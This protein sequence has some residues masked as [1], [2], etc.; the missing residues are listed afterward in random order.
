M[1]IRDRIIEFR[2]VS[3]DELVPNPKNW[4][5]HSDLQRKALKDLVAQIGFVGAELARLLPDGRLMLIDGHLR[6]ETFAGAVLPVLV[7]DLNEAEADAVLAAA[8]NK[9]PAWWLKVFQDT[10]SAGVTEFDAA[11]LIE[12]GMARP[13]REFKPSPGSTSLTTS[14]GRPAPPHSRQ[15]EGSEYAPAVGGYVP[16]TGNAHLDDGSSRP[17]IARQLT[18]LVEKP[19]VT[20]EQIKRLK[21]LGYWVEDLNVNPHVPKGGGPNVKITQ[22]ITAGESADPVTNT[23]GFAWIVVD[24]W[25]EALAHALDH[26]LITDNKAS[27]G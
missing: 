2:R 7:T 1:D 21:A 13:V 26:G 20:A 8:S 23:I 16:H 3:A 5:G 9:Y 24:G 25:V 27:E 4:R 18:E 14:V 17:E 11:A 10:G 6:K 12:M 22:R 15:G 19:M